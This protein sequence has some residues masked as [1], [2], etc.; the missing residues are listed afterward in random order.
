MYLGEIRS[1]FP[2]RSLATTIIAQLN[3][4]N[5]AVHFLNHVYQV[6]LSA[7]DLARCST[8][9][10]YL[11]GRRGKKLQVFGLGHGLTISTSRQPT[12]QQT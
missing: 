6:P 4:E 11:G 5:K 12:W 8:K 7:M 10:G 1:T 3:G 2:V 9:D